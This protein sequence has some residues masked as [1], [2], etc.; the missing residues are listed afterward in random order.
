MQPQN[1]KSAPNSSRKKKKAINDSVLQNLA[2]RVSAKIEEGD[3]LGAVRLAASNDTLVA[4]DDDTSAVL[5][6]FHCLR[7]APTYDSQL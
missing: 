6:Q 7:A 4:N 3:V 5:R 2:E 1:A